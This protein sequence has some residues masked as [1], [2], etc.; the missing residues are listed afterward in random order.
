MCV[1]IS[2]QAQ[3]SWIVTNAGMIFLPSNKSYAHAEVRLNIS[4]W[5]FIKPPS[6]DQ[7]TAYSTKCTFVNKQGFW[8]LKF[9]LS[10]SKDHVRSLGDLFFLLMVLLVHCAS[11][12][13][14]PETIPLPSYSLQLA[15]MF[16]GWHSDQLQKIPSFLIRGQS[17]SRFTWD[18]CYHPSS[19]K[20]LSPDHWSIGCVKNS[21]ALFTHSTKVQF[22]PI[23][24]KCTRQ[25]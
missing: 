9:D 22:A 25:V 19:T 21:R 4:C 12:I 8:H 10:R 2:H 16:Q 6:E 15:Y 3:Q 24:E 17:F 13:C 1:H 20:I 5:S 23:N 7:T 14:P 11:P 18:H